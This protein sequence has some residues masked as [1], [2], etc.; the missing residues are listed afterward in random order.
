MGREALW[1]PLAVRNP[2]CGPRIQIAWYT[3][4]AGQ[5]RGAVV[6]NSP[7]SAHTDST[8]ISNVSEQLTAF[9]KKCLASEGCQ[10]GIMGM[11]GTP[12]VFARQAVKDGQERLGWVWMAQPIVPAMLQ[13]ISGEMG[14][15]LVLVSGNL[16]AGAHKADAAMRWIWDDGE[17]GV[18][19]AW[20]AR[21]A[22]GNCLGYFRA[23]IPVACIHQQ[24]TS[25]RRIVLIVLS[26]S[27]GLVLLTILGVHILV[28]GPVM[29]LLR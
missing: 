12:A 10:G 27:V 4:A 11:P 25:G 17:R 29:R 22:L 9:S 26:L 5:L 6:R 19:I 28:A 3:D 20:P 15:Q 7:E 8:H 1:R 18:N 23:W 24:A 16:P 2:M 13:Q 14:G 21:D